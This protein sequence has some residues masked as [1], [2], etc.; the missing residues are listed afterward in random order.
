MSFWWGEGAE[1]LRVTFV[2][3]GLNFSTETHPPTYPG[4]QSTSHTEVAWRQLGWS[5]SE[6]GAGWAKSK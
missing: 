1:M 5:P 3:P 2:H 4:K 6:V